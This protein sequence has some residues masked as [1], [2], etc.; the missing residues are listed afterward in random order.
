[1]W[2][3]A[4]ATWRGLAHKSGAKILWTFYIL[5]HSC[6]FC[7]ERA[8]SYLAMHTWTKKGTNSW[9][10]QSAVEIRIAHVWS[11]NNLV[12][13]CAQN[14]SGNAIVSYYSTSILFWEFGSPN[15]MKYLSVE[16]K[17]RKNKRGRQHHDNFLHTFLFRKWISSWCS[18][19]WRVLTED[20]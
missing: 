12:S 6:F 14:G 1:M 7:R 15:N 4:I 19:C 16:E 20:I 2:L 18:N 17:K 9:C 5:M 8:W 13:C 11:Q 3:T 10:D